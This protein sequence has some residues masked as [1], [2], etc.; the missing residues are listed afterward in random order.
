VQPNSLSIWTHHLNSIKWWDASFSPKGCP[1]PIN[2][3]AIT[4]GSGTQWR[5]IYKSATNKGVSFVGGKFESVSVGGFLANGG[6][7]LLSAKY[8]LGADMVL[9]IELV[10]ADGEYITANECQNQDYFWAMRGVSFCITF[11]RTLSQLTY[12]SRVAVRHTALFY[13]IQ[14]KAFEPDRWLNTVEPSMDGIRLL[15]FTLSGPRSQWQVGL[16]ISGAI[17]AEAVWSVSLS[18]CQI[19]PPW[20]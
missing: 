2:G 15:T 20:R 8:G 10:N 6:H 13:P 7:G 14:S 11:S 16:D 4:V 19:Q 3:H 18:T 17:R 12:N 5:D 9:Q 1:R